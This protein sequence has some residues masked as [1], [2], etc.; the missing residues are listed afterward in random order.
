FADID[1]IPTFNI[2]SDEL[3]VNT[4]TLDKSLSLVLNGFTRLI[5]II[6]TTTTIDK[7][8][9][10]RKKQDTILLLSPNK[11]EFNTKRDELISCI[12]QKL[13]IKKNT[14]AICNNSIQRNKLFYTENPKIILAKKHIADNNLEIKKINEQI[15]EIE[16]F[17]KEA[18]DDINTIKPLIIEQVQL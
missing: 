2:Q 9:A 8:N 14:I 5:E 1:K 18:L 7:W 16:K 17:Q 6:S 11:N 15:V 10:Y 3:N 4:Q 12:H 13:E